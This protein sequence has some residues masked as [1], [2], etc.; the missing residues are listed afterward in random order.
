ML[1]PPTSYALQVLN[2]SGEYLRRTSSSSKVILSPLAL[3]FDVLVVEVEEGAFLLF[4]FNPLVAGTT[5]GGIVAVV[6]AGVCVKREEGVVGV[7][8]GVNSVSI[9]VCLVG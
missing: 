2:C 7:E 8:V 5:A 4:C 1:T 9:A 3:P 6:G